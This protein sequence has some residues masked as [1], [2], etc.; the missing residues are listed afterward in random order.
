MPWGEKT[1]LWRSLKYLVLPAPTQVPTCRRTRL[2]N[3]APEKQG[4]PSN[5]PLLERGEMI[6]KCRPKMCRHVLYVKE[7]YLIEYIEADLY[8]SVSQIMI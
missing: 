2:T 8:F 7:L 3:P 5:A 4:G 6:D 1:F